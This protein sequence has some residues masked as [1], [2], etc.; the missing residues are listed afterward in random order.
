MRLTYRKNEAVLQLS[1]TLSHSWH[2]HS[3]LHDYDTDTTLCIATQ[4]IL[5]KKIAA[6]CGIHDT[7]C[8]TTNSDSISKNKIP[9]LK[10][11]VSLARCNK[12]YQGTHNYLVKSNFGEW[13]IY[14]NNRQQKEICFLTFS[15]HR[16]SFFE[17]V[18]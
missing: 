1:T 6:S 14:P 10:K 5:S 12:Y 3:I 15:R 17:D 11:G 18:T 16:R 7:Y 9:L 2:R 13:K 8:D 4:I